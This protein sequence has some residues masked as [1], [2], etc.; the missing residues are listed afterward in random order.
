M[1]VASLLP[2]CYGLATGSLRGNWCDGFWSYHRCILQHFDLSL[3][4]I[5]VEVCR[6]RQK[7]DFVAVE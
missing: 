6:H 1:E 2:S 7:V 3:V 5:G 4:H